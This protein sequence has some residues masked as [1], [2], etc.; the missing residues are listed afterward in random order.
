MKPLVSICCITYNHEKYIE[1][2]LDSFLMQETNF[3]FEIIVHDDAST[4]NT[5]KTIRKYEKKYPSKIIGIYQK[6]NQYSKG[7]SPL[8]D[9]VLPKVKGKYIATCEGD[10]YWI[11]SKKLQKQIEFLESNSEYVMCF[12][13]VK[14][15]DTDKNFT[16]NYIGP[17]RKGSKEY[18]IKDTVKSGFVHVSSRVIKTYVYKAERPA[19][20]SHAMHGD[21][22]LALFL[23]AEGKV[24][25]IDELM[26]AYR[27]GVENSIMTKYKE[28]YSGKKEIK[29]QLNRIKTLEMADKYYDYKYSEEISDVNLT[30][31]LIIA[32]LKKDLSPYARNIYINYI[33][34]YGLKKF[35]KIFFNKK[36][37][38]L[39]MRCFKIRKKLFLKGKRK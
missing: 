23:S 21:Y 10:D 26:S 33:N 8:N 15:V 14:V 36:Y 12:H 3:P 37:P 13:P 29:Y 34:Q 4:D 35:I 11:D 39:T 31:K 25:C 22:A 38:K 9:Y 2:A 5:A 18:T 19:Y 20:M 6:E 7:R 27:K 32:L 16:G 17:Y 24:Y 30:S 28:K 1:D